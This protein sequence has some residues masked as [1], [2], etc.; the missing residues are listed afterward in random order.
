VDDQVDRH[1]LRRQP[2]GP[3]HLL[4]VIDVDVTQQRKPQELHGL[5]PV[6]ERDDPGIALFLELAN[7]G[8]PAIFHHPLLNH[9]Q[10]GND[11]DEYPE[12]VP[13]V[14]HSRLLFN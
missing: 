8:E 11:D 4:G 1:L 14:V 2:D 5:L 10:Q 6:D 3:Q 9:G 7:Q 13:D 12:Q